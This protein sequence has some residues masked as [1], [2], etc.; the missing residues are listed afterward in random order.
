M[1][2]NNTYLIWVRIPTKSSSTLWLRDAE[3]SVYLQSKDVAIDLAS[4]KKLIAIIKSYIEQWTIYL[5]CY[6]ILQLHL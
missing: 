5:P 3:V 1:A 2:S 6:I 4:E